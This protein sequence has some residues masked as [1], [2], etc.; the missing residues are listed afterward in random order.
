MLFLLYINDID[1]NLLNTNVKL[2]ADDTVIYSTNKDEAVAYENVE[3]DL[4]NLMKWCDNNQ[5]TVNIKKT[6]LVL[7]GTKEML[8]NSRHIDMYMG[9]EKLQYVNDY[10]YLGIKLDNKFTFELHANECCRHGIHKIYILAKIRR[11]INTHQALTIYKSMMHN[12][13][14]GTYDR[15]QKLQNKAL[16][17]CLQK[18]NRCNVNQLHRDGNTNMLVDRRKANLCNFMYKRK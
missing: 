4:K 1:Y 18:N 9:T 15:M 5:L 17:L 16:R 14:V 12:L 8:R 6:K 3:S 2:Y 11:Y 7:F 13:K 10:M